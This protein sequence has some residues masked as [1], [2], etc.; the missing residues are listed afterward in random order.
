MYSKWWL[1]SCQWLKNCPVDLSFPTTALKWKQM[2]RKGS[3]NNT[4]IKTN[5]HTTHTHTHTRWISRSTIRCY[6]LVYAA[7]SRWAGLL[8]SS[9][10][11]A[12][13]YTQWYSYVVGGAGGRAAVA[14]L[15]KCL[16][17]VFNKHLFEDA[18]TLF[19]VV[20]TQSP[21]WNFLQ[22]Y[23]LQN[24]RKNST[25]SNTHKCRNKLS[26]RK[27]FDERKKKRKTKSKV[28]LSNGNDCGW[29]QL[30]ASYYIQENWTH[31]IICLWFPHHRCF[32]NNLDAF[33]YQIYRIL[34]KISGIFERCRFSSNRTIVRVCELCEHEH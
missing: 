11:N 14:G 6:L 18:F 32:S 3:N 28:T 10:F 8:S 33:D 12:K 19:C 7:H 22:K 21:T 9:T 24:K 16:M 25:N 30:F 17:Y 34:S 20:R 5:I 27:E 29:A 4:N 13:I 1:H 2:K 26:V 31:I 15:L 23:A